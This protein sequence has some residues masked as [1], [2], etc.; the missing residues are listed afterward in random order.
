MAD[1]N[2]KGRAERERGVGIEEEYARQPQ[3]FLGHGG[4]VEEGLRGKGRI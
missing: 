3:Q 2:T 1:E 4:V